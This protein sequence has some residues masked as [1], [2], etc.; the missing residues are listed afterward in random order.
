[1][2]YMTEKEM[3]EWLREQQRIH[4]WYSLPW[5]VIAFSVFVGLPV[6]LLFI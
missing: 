6:S 5:L 2:N 4:F 3:W 1:M